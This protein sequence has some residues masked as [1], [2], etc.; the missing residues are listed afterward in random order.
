MQ[1]STMQSVFSPADAAQV[2]AM[3][4]PRDN[5]TELMPFS[6]NNDHLQALENEAKFMVAVAAL[7]RGKSPTDDATEQPPCFAFLKNGTDL[8]QAALELADIS[9][10]NRR[11][12]HLSSQQG[13]CLNFLRFCDKWELDSIEQTIVLLLLMQFSSP[14]FFAVY[15]SSGLERNCDN[16]MEIGAILSIIS[17]DLGLQLEYRRYFSIHGKLLRNELLTSN[18]QFMDNT[19]SILRMSAYLHERYVRHIVGDTN[20]YH[21]AFRFIK[22][23]RSSVDLGQVVLPE[24]IKREVVMRAERFIAG[25]RNGTFDQLDDFF[26]YGTGLAFIFHGPS[27][28]GKTMLA[29]GLA[30][31]LSCPLVSLN[32]EDLSNIPMSNNEIMETLFREAALIDGI[33][34]LDECDDIFGGSANS[35]LSRSLLLEIEKSRC[36]TILATNKPVE[37]D[38]AME[39]RIGMK[40]Q[41]ALPDAGLRLQ[42]WQA[43]IPPN[44]VLESG[45]N[46]NELAERYKFNGGLIKNSILMAITAA[47]REE[48][49]RIT[50]TQQDL[51][52]AS[53]LQTSTMS[54]LNRICTVVKPEASLA[55]LLLGRRQRDE[56]SGLAHAWTWLSSQ[57]LGFNLLFNCNDID[58]GIKAVVGLAAECRMILHLYDFT[59]V[60]SLS[61]DA[62]L[63]DPVTQRRVS[64]M[65]AVFSNASSEKVMTLF[66]D[67]GGELGRIIDR[68]TDKDKLTDIAYAEMFSQMR[69]NKGMFCVVTKDIKTGCIPIEFHQLIT[70]EYPSEEQ[71]MRCWEACLGVNIL[72]DDHLVEIVRQY[73]LHAE[74]IKFIARQATVKSIMQ[75]SNRVPDKKCILD[76]V[77]GYRKKITAPVLFGAAA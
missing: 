54:E 65:T 25:R 17:G 20:Q 37:L 61:E 66:V 34:F 4:A 35:Q 72:D 67:H 1:T 49:S 41:F 44:I 10:E 56:L 11:R 9:A 21:V 22:Q 46:L 7:R 31:H 29:K 40:V 8:N 38:P 16:G 48:D 39:R 45:V 62:K 18:Y 55:D 36:I 60:S 43:L 27:G 13:I 33:V 52:Q 58:T 59:K 70:L 6:G 19:S 30:N 75:S 76:V 50:L 26:S 2:I 3:K 69:K 14:T 42:M 64:P 47:S 63:L 68:D 77:S 74:E 5:K 12:E 28:T 24:D 23:E 15:Q 32:A 71:Q 57:D 53:E 51:E 73:P